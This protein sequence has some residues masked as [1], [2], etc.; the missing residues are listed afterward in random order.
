MTSTASPA[1][2]RS[3]PKSTSVA[4]DAD[5]GRGQ[6]ELVAS[7]FGDDL[8]VAGDDGDA[9]FARRRR[10]R[11]G[12]L[13][14]KVDR[15]PFLD[16]RGAGEIE[17][18]RAANR[19]IVDRA[20]HREPADI[21]AGEDERIDD[22]GIC[23]EGNSV[24]AP[25]EIGEIEPRLIVQRGEQRIVERPDEHVVDQILHRLA[26]AAMGERHGRHMDPAQRPCAKGRDDV[27]S[28]AS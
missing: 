26:A 28:A 10:H 14:Q 24:A 27:H 21:A 17:R 25:R 6:E 1:R 23:G 22:E 11:R 12:D 8:G 16:D 7:A 18:N 15:H 20:A 4:D 5:P 9:R 19:E 2:A 13:A 3:A